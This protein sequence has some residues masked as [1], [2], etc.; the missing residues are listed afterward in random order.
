MLTSLLLTI[1]MMVPSGTNDNPYKSLTLRKRF[2]Q[3]YNRQVVV[4]YN[5]PCRRSYY[6]HGRYHT[7]VVV[8]K[9]T[10]YVRTYKRSRVTR[11]RPGTARYVR[12]YRTTRRR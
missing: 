5:D 4:I 7:R 9:S 12:R 6:D 8:P 11:S 3:R 1:A 10:R 2:E